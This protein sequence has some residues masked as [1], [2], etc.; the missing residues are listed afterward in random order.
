MK[1]LIW[2]Q[3]LLGIGH[4]RRAAL[5]ARAMTEAGLDVTV[6]SGGF[7]VAGVSYGDA[8]VVQLPPARAADKSF[9]LLVTEGD[10]SLDDAWKERR[11]AALLSLGHEVDPDILLL[12]TYPF[13]RRQFRF[14]LLPLL[15]HLKIGRASCR[16]RV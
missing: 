5:I 9:K 10:R 15:D 13:G 3:H 2:V 14:E 11:R 7:P 1:A 8:R 4:V 6:A 12:E 16:E